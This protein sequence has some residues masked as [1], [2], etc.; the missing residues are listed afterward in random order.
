MFQEGLLPV[1]KVIIGHAS[2][3]RCQSDDGSVIQWHVFNMNPNNYVTYD[4]LLSRQFGNNAQYFLNNTATGVDSNANLFSTIQ[5]PEDLSSIVSGNSVIYNRV[6]TIIESFI[7]KGD[8][9]IEDLVFVNHHWALRMD[10]NPIRL[11]AYV[12]STQKFWT[13]VANSALVEMDAIKTN[14]ST[15][16]DRKNDTSVDTWGLQSRGY[17]YL[18]MPG[19]ISKPVL[20]F[21]TLGT[22]QNGST[23]I[24]T[25]E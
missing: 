25:E 10:N 24:I 13:L 19:R 11:Q 5:Y 20:M 3:V 14:N 4:A 12:K 6:Q 16:L 8:G 17:N 23:F 22:D 21:D 2:L 18:M 15:N 7:S 9:T 1:Q